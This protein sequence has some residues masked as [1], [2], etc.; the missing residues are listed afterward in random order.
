TTYTARQAVVLATGTGPSLPPIPGLAEAHGWTNRQGT[1]SQQVPGRLVVLGGGVAG[2]ELGQ[3]WLTLGS[4]VA[5]IAG[6]PRLLAREEEFA[7]RFVPDGL[8]ARG[9][10]IHTNSRATSVERDVNEVRVT[11]EGGGVVNGDEILVAVG[12]TPATREIGLETVGL[13]PGRYV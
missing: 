2:V 3:A 12:R 1:T 8:A 11:L 5:V 9:V 7:R 4:E 13:E 6:G 10:E